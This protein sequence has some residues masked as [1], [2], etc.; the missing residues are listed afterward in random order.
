MRSQN[1]ARRAAK[2]RQRDTRRAQQQ[3]RERPGLFEGVQDLALDLAAA[4]RATLA[5]DTTA[6]EEAAFTAVTTVAPH[7]AQ[8]IMVDLL[9]DCLTH[10]WRGGWQPIDLHEVTVRQLTREHTK[11]L[12]EATAAAM[13]PFAKDTVHRTWLD[14]LDAAAPADK[15]TTRADVAWSVTLG[16]QLLA[17][18]MGLPRIELLLALP[19]TFRPG[20]AGQE[21]D[22]KVLGRVRGLLAKAESTEFDEEA[23]AL[24]AKAQELMT[25]YNLDQLLVEAGT[26]PPVAGGRR[27]WL[28]SPYASA[29]ALLAAAVGGANHCSVVWTEA[30]GYVTVIGDERDLVATE[31]VLTSL[32]VQAGRAMAH[33]SKQVGGQKRSYRQSFLVAYA[34]RVGERLQDVSEQVAVEVGGSALVLVRA[35]QD[36]RVEQAREA[37][38]PRTTSRSVSVSNY[39]GYVEGRAAA[40]Q[41]ILQGRTQLPRT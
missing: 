13:A 34:Q 14:Q 5:G 38:F 21:V 18:L 1:R 20:S 28:E 11:V 41:A 10:T 32:L 15:S 23:E 30:L 9:S 16:I 4:A 40:D 2:Q 24:S 35:A 17:L 33:G 29:K 12:G 3:P 39:Q 37:M 26:A 25:R 8:Q 27:I 6:A 7:R 22:Q 36:E 19:G 31:L